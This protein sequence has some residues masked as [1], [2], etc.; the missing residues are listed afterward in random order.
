MAI[1]SKTVGGALTAAMTPPA[2]V[3][4][5]LQKRPELFNTYL[6]VHLVSA[7]PCR[8]NCPTFRSSAI[9]CAHPP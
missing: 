6:A 8:L 7:K 2:Q 9:V 5:T 4:K 1:A 3:A